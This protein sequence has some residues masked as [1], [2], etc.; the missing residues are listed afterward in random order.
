M[1]KAARNDPVSAHTRASMLRRL[2]HSSAISKKDEP[3]SGSAAKRQKKGSRKKM[4]KHNDTVEDESYEK[5]N[6]AQRRKD[7]RASLPGNVEKTMAQAADDQD[8]AALKAALN[9]PTDEQKKEAA[10]PAIVS[11]MMKRVP[12]PP[13]SCQPQVIYQL[14][15]VDSTSDCVVGCL[16]QT[17]LQMQGQANTVLKAVPDVVGHRV[18]HRLGGKIVLLLQLADGSAARN[19]VRYGIEGETRRFD[20][21]KRGAVYKRQQCNRF[22]IVF[23]WPPVLN[24]HLHAVTEFFSSISVRPCPEGGYQ[25][26]LPSIKM[27][28]DFCYIVDGLT[29]CGT[30]L[31]CQV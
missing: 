26:E 4:T 28:D 9:L 22:A 12:P 11:L 8:S 20:Y 27:C 16:V 17:D 23:N 15:T 7:A 21:V 30:I 2:K 14:A 24:G 10:C 19:L 6:Y 13:P 1:G 18:E 25:V 31:G 3:G 5:T 29:L